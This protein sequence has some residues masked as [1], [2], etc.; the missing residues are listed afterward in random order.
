[1]KPK[2]VCILIILYWAFI[3]IWLVMNGPKGK[4]SNKLF[5]KIFNQLLRLYGS[6]HAK[7]MGNDGKM[8]HLKPQISRKPNKLASKFFH[9]WF[10]RTKLPKNRFE[11]LHPDLQFKSSFLKKNVFFEPSRARKFFFESRPTK[12]TP[13]CN[14]KYNKKKRIEKYPSDRQTDRDQLWGIP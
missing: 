6:S 12:G 1:M 2:I 11:I 4:G 7:C 14:K 5:K 9:H 3:N 8:V 13:H 10:Q